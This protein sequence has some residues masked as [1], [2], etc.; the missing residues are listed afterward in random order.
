[1]TPYIVSGSG[2]LT[3][4]TVACTFAPIFREHEVKIISKVPYVPAFSAS[5]GHRLRA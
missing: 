1:M 3:P 2:G 5:G 4:S